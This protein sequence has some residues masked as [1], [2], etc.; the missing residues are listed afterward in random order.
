M[1]QNSPSIFDLSMTETSH[2]LLLIDTDN[3]VSGDVRQKLVSVG[4]NVHIMTNDSEG[5][6]YIRQH[7]P[8]VILIS[9]NDNLMGLVKEIRTY[10]Q[11]PIIILLKLDEVHNA[12]PLLAHGATDYAL[13]APGGEDLM[14]H[15]L[16]RHVHH[17]GIDRQVNQSSGSTANIEEKLKLLVSDQ[18][19]GFRLQRGMMPLSPATIGEVK[20][21]HRIF[22]SLI[23]SGDFIDYFPLS[24]DKILF[25][26][27]DVSGHGASSAFVT[28]LLR[29]MSRRLEQNFSSLNLSDTGSILNWMNNELLL[30]ELEH[31]VTMFLAVI[32]LSTRQLMYSNAAHF[33]AAILS[34]QEYT[35]YLESGGRPLGLFKTVEYESTKVDLPEACTLILFSDGVFEIMPQDTLMGK[36]EQLLSLV[37]NGMKN[38]ESLAGKLGMAEAVNLPDD[39]AVFTIDV[40]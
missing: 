17:T 37:K 22:P 14:L 30:C 40:G 9:W 25:Y 18:Q 34:S 31:H 20:L 38:V 28:I 8:E 13:L 21:E 5:L 39:I 15:V 6:L 32:D 26:L 23:L 11:N 19:A 12:V 29:S 7:D 24:R 3:R 27:A 10:V 35:C 36:E 2:N 33:P 4:Y 1:A 16:G